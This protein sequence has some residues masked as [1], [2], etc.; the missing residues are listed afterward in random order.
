MGISTLQA[1]Q[2]L[3]GAQHYPEATL[4][5]VATP[6]GN[7]ADISLRSL[8]ILQLADAIA[9]EDTRTT[10][11]LLQQYGIAVPALFSL[12]QHNEAAAAQ[13]VMSRLEQKQRVVL[14][15]DAGTPAISDPGAQTVKRVSQAGFRV[16]PIPGASSVITA[17]SAAGITQGSTLF[18]GFLSHKSQ[19]RLQTL[20]EISNTPY[21]IVLLEAPH[22]MKKL[23][24]EL[25]EIAPQRQITIV[26]ELTKQFEQIV[27]LT[28]QDMPAWLHQPEHQKGEFVCI[29]HAP[30][31][32]NAQPS[33]TAMDGALQLALQHLSTKTSAQLLAQLTGV[34]KKT[35]YLRALELQGK[36]PETHE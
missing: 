18:H 30:P 22:R 35:L 8:Y 16:M 31:S 21:N 32:D 26:R 24:E 36:S 4:Y 17:L 29:L 19:E 14:V 13:E 28:V 11:N 12:H 33:S 3:A 23:S 25:Q 9:C 34:P 27:T 15:S 7:L 5:L 20:K 2:E 6:I 10:R 1:A